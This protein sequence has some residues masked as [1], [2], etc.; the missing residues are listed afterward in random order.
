MQWTPS[1][2][3]ARLH[4]VHH[5]CWLNAPVI[6][7]PGRFNKWL[8]LVVALTCGASIRDVSAQAPAA[9]AMLRVACDGPAVNAEVTIN[10][11]FK[12]GCPIDVPVVAGSLRIRVMK[13][14]DSERELIFEQ[15]VRM[16]GGTVKRIDV[17][18]GAPR[19][20][21]DAQRLATQRG[22]EA[23]AEAEAKK[24]LRFSEAAGSV[25]LD[26]STGL[27]WTQ[28][29]NGSGI[30]WNEAG[31]YC[32]AKGSG[33]DL[34]SRDELVGLVD[35]TQSQ[36]CGTSTCKVS[37]KFRLTEWL[38]WSRERSGY[39]AWMVYLHDGDLF[40]EMV[41]VGGESK[42]ALCVRRP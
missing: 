19:L 27:Q 23:K 18:F 42:R 5:S 17:E 7:L 13:K 37:P 40:D 34:P 28:S 29:D 2:L 9:T 32:R 30:N 11:E 1:I 26:T 14:V 12:G 8:P 35:K 38:F 25:L 33:W 6:S 4:S 24:A 39:Y 16:V 20:N 41:V 3:L 31:A 36:K 22:Q 15:E 10:G 21:A